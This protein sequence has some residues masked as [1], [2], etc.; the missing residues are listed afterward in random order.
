MAVIGAFSHM[1]IRPAMRAF[2]RSNFSFFQLLISGAACP[3][4]WETQPVELNPPLN[5]LCRGPH[6]VQLPLGMLG[7]LAFELLLGMY[8]V[9]L[10]GSGRS[11]SWKS[12]F[13][14]GQ[15]L[16]SHPLLR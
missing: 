6:P 9:P 11:M 13:P 7:A 16:L 14:S 2:E 10:K 3:D 15:K 5:C 1:R 8:G 4:D 12:R